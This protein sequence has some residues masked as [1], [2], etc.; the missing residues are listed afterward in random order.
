[1]Q[2][3]VQGLPQFL[4]QLNKCRLHRRHSCNGIRFCLQTRVNPSSTELG[5]LGLKKFDNAVVGLKL[6]VL[7]VKTTSCSNKACPLFS[8][9]KLDPH[10]SCTSKMD[11]SKRS[12]RALERPRVASTTAKGSACPVLGLLLSAISL[13]VCTGASTPM[14][15][16]VSFSLIRLLQRYA[17][18][19]HGCPLHYIDNNLALGLCG[20]T[21]CCYSLAGGPNLPILR[22]ENFGISAVAYSSANDWIAYAEKVLW[23]LESEDPVRLADGQLKWAAENASFSPA[24]SDH[25][26]VNGSGKI[27]VW[28]FEQS[29]KRISFT[30][31]VLYMA[32]FKPQCHA[33]ALN[34]LHIYVGGAMGEVLIVETKM[35][36]DHTWDTHPE[37][38]FLCLLPSREKVAAICVGDYHISVIGVDG[39]ISWFYIRGATS[40]PKL[41]VTEGQSKVKVPREKAGG[42]GAKEKQKEAPTEPIESTREGNEPDAFLLS[43]TDLDIYDIVVAAYRSDGLQLVLG[44][45]NGS[46]VVVKLN[47]QFLQSLAH[48]YSPRNSRSQQQIAQIECRTVHHDGPICG[49][50]TLSD[51]KFIATCGDDGTLRVW[52]AERT[53]ELSRQCFQSPLGC[54]ESNEENSALVVGSATGYL[55]VAKVDSGG[56]SAIIFRTKLHNTS[57]D[58][59]GFSPDARYVIA[60]SRTDGRLYFL[61]S[62]PVDVGDL[63]LL[64]YAVLQ[65]VVLAFA[66]DIVS[67][68]EDLVVLL[69]LGRGEI[70]KLKVPTTKAPGGG[71]FFENKALRRISFRIASPALAMQV[72]KYYLEKEGVER[73]VLWALGQDKKLQQY[74][75]PDSLQAWTGPDAMPFTPHFIIP[76]HAKPGTALFLSAERSLLVT[77]A[78]DGSLQI[79]TQVLDPLSTPQKVS[80][81]T[82]HRS[83]SLHMSTGRSPPGL[84]PRE[85]NLV[86]HV[87]DDEDEPAL[88]DKHVQ[89]SEERSALVS[90]AYATETR[91]KISLLRREFQEI[92]D[93]N[94]KVPELERLNRT[95]LVVDLDLERTLRQL[96]EKRVV[97]AREEVKVENLRKD[98]LAERIKAECWTPMVEPEIHIWPFIQGYAVP[99]FPMHARH[100]APNKMGRVAKLL[101]IVEMQEIVYIQKT[102]F[103]MVTQEAEH[104][105]GHPLGTE[106]IQEGN[107]NEIASIANASENPQGDSG[108]EG[109]DAQ[110]ETLGEEAEDGKGTSSGGKESS[111]P[112]TTSVPRPSTV[113]LPLPLIPL[114]ENEEDE[115]ITPEMLEMGPTEALLYHS[116]DLSSPKRKRIQQINPVIMQRLLLQT[117]LL[118]IREGFND[119]MEECGR[120]KTHTIE[121]IREMH[122]RIRE[123]QKSLGQK[124]D[125][126]L[127]ELNRT[128]VCTGSGL[129][130]YNAFPVSEQD[131]LEAVKRDEEEAFRLKMG[132]DAPE[133]A[134]MDMMGGKLE[135]R[136]EEDVTVEVQIEKLS[137]MSGNPKTFTKEQ[138]KE[139]KEFE[140]KLKL[141]KEEREKKIRAQEAE[142]RKLKTD[143]QE[144]MV[145]FDASVLELYGSRL[146][147]ECKCVEVEQTIARLS[148][149][150]EDEELRDEKTEAEL[151][152][153]LDS[154]KASKGRSVSAVTEF[155]R[156]VDEFRDRFEYL[157]Q[158]DKAL[159]RNFKKDFQDCGDVVGLLY[160]HFKKRRASPKG[161]PKPA[162]HQKEQPRRGSLQQ[163]RRSSALQRRSLL[164][165]KPPS[166][167]PFDDRPEDVE[168]EHWE[169][170][171][172][173]RNRKIQ[174][175]DE[176]KKNGE[177]LQRMGTYLNKLSS[178][179]DAIRKRI[180]KALRNFAEFRDN[181]EKKKRDMAFV[182]HLKQGL[183]EVV[184][185]PLEEAYDDAVLLPRNIVQEFNSVILREA[186]SKIEMLVA[187]KDFKRG[188]F[189][190]Q[191]EI[192]RHQ[193]LQGT[194]SEK[195]KYIQLLRNTK[196]LQK[197]IKNKDDVASASESVGLENRLEHNK[198][199][200]EKKVDEKNVH[201]QQ[202]NDRTNDI[203]SQNKDLQLQAAKLHQEFSFQHQL[204]SKSLG[205]ETKDA[206][207]KE[208]ISSINTKSKLRDI[209]KQ[210][211]ARIVG[212]KEGLHAFKMRAHPQ[213][214]GT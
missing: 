64:G 170:L 7:H 138:I 109:V 147:E 131:R 130:D 52:D 11:D 198:K 38:K 163:R 155:K 206:A 20:N 132:G 4:E 93:K 201:L 61:K 126:I 28:T 46:M 176:V 23:D 91:N 58:K 159:D 10:F 120:S 77:G 59:V 214:A 156:E 143:I 31:K 191:W 98:L 171:L 26:C 197:V 1:M 66:W 118:E 202:L 80:A 45:S 39:N 136:E 115:V 148:T 119:K 17:I 181:R 2:K 97:A 92:F 180:E 189:D 54:I 174:K 9:S 179:D 164:L 207:L 194:L 150:I 25:I 124:D 75:L 34:G 6:S 104:G 169:R 43:G 21:L 166:I 112:E 113:P 205:G 165:L 182:L 67:S 139:L 29:F 53:R 86:S 158:E 145:M 37:W 141:M 30:C 83:S 3:L 5:Q 70:V 81:V 199:L 22:G 190:V 88:T 188:I 101:R 79:R 102:K 208:K 82:Y 129:N 19:Y 65:D 200:H 18:G 78:E 94:D 154:L 127:P 15:F 55:N 48:G 84:S 13:L 192:Q 128:D 99:N 76:G 107:S 62:S 140:Q 72:G 122:T 203:R 69:S 187:I 162:A 71:F 73:K 168:P 44:T 68:G 105:E 185:K 110:T 63:N 33:W 134:L 12:G 135:M 149:E 14:K 8:S 95:E 210:Q 111:D 87:E 183:L 211:V 212:L 172:A 42:K 60:I 96:G 49:I 56:R 47:G 74:R 108:T 41:P 152:K 153:A 137:W 85:S 209:S 40:I 196:A 117:H 24:N 125:F 157:I 167:D 89:T 100:R 173:A 160:K 123:L 186:N 57:I 106:S 90:Q 121:K 36:V 184:L 103:I 178:L 177:T 204:C 51:G 32:P 213:F 16:L 195:I 50:V 116:F 175:E 161:S 114:E 27:A 133:R 193:V 35:V 146:Q 142:I 144:S 151:A